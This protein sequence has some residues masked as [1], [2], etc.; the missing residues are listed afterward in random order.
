[1][2]D[3]FN[4]IT[5]QFYN[6]L[7]NDTSLRLSKSID[8]RNRKWFLLACDI[9][10]KENNLHSAVYEK[11]VTELSRVLDDLDETELIFVV[12]CTRKA[13]KR[14]QGK[15]NPGIQKLMEFINERI[16]TSTIK[17]TNNVLKLILTC[18]AS[19]VGFDWSTN[20]LEVLYNDFSSPIDRIDFVEFNFIKCEKSFSAIKQQT[21]RLLILLDPQRLPR[22]DRYLF[23][24]FSISDSQLIQFMKRLLKANSDLFYE[25]YN[26][27]IYEELL[28]VDF[29]IEQL[30]T[31]S[32][33]LLELLLLVFGTRPKLKK[34]KIHF[35]NF[36]MLL[37]LKLETF[38]EGFP[39]NCE[40]LIEK[41][42]IFMNKI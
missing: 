26:F 25:F 17:C 41:L 6:E 4:Q 14:L 37:L 29:F 16:T 36:H 7:C 19:E 5:I 40:F 3:P 11:T 24:L 42:R 1:M 27:V 39:F 23:D 15:S 28:S 33:D 30:L 31:D 32:V 18:K 21:E 38:P 8:R 9:V 22:T 35:K 20:F 2:I 12:D 10:L 34:H 13:L